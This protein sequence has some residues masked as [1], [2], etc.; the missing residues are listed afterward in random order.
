[1]KNERREEHDLG[2]SLSDRKLVS[3]KKRNWYLAKKKRVIV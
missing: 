3:Y 1:M 2:I